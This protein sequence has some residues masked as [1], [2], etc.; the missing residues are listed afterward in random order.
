MQGDFKAPR[1]CV[2]LSRE[3]IIGSCSLEVLDEEVQ[4]AC[5]VSCD[6]VLLTLSRSQ[7]S[8]AKV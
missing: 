5:V 8:F 3:G 4:C 2:N 1:M 6:L 7:I